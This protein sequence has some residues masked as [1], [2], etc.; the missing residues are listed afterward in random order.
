MDPSNL[1]PSSLNT[2]DDT[3]NSSF[4]GISISFA[5]E[6]QILGEKDPYN[7]QDYLKAFSSIILDQLNT[8]DM[9]ALLESQQQ[10]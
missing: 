8:Q 6:K 3:F 2:T 10:M 7:E 9:K 1:P 4:S 5:N